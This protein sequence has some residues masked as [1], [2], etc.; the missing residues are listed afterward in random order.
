MTIAASVVIAAVKYLIRQAT[1]W[2]GKPGTS[3]DRAFPGTMLE[4][5]RVKL[6][7][8]NSSR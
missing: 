5:P 3:P 2:L 6:A 7:S 8:A 1:G 4:Q